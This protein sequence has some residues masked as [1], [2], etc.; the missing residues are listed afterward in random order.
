VSMVRGPGEEAYKDASR[1]ALKRRGSSV[2]HA[3]NKRGRSRAG[4]EN[5]KGTVTIRIPEERGHR[6]RSA[7]GESANV[8][9]LLE[10]TVRNDSRLG[11]GDV[12]FTARHQVKENPIH[13]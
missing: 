12:A 5:L 3:K 9:D 4:V 6:G 13:A 1:K 8:D 7:P 2:K 10:G 11:G